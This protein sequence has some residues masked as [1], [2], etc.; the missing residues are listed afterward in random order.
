VVAPD[1][2]AAVTADLA[3]EIALGP[4]D[5]LVR[6]KAKAIARAAIAPDTPTREL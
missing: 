5:V 3:A 4:R 1:D 6:T 2:F